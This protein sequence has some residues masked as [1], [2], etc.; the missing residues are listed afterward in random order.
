MEHEQI[1]TLI[2]G[3]VVN[4]DPGVKFQILTDNISTLTVLDCLTKK[5]FI[6]TAGD[7]IF[8]GQYLYYSKED[9]LRIGVIFGQSIPK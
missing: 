3:D 2:E 1:L 6:K 4:N 7:I 5:N 8:S 9:I